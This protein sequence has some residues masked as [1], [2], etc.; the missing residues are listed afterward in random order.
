MWMTIIRASSSSSSSSSSSG[1][2]QSEKEGWE[3][4]PLI[5]VA[6]YSGF[7]LPRGCKF[8]RAHLWMWVQH[9]LDCIIWTQGKLVSTL[10][11]YWSDLWNATVK[12]SRCA[13]RL[14]Y[15]NMEPHCVCV[16]F[17][18]SLSTFL[19]LYPNDK[20]GTDKQQVSLLPP[21][22]PVVRF[23]IWLRKEQEALSK[24]WG[25][26]TTTTKKPQLH[27]RTPQREK[28]LSFKAKT[29]AS[30]FF[31]CCNSTQLKLELYSFFFF[32]SVRNWIEIQKTK[33]AKQKNIQGFLNATLLFLALTIHYA[34][35]VH[36]DR[37]GTIKISCA[38]ICIDTAF[39]VC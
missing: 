16:C 33:K 15:G 28:K 34:V 10:T 2:R 24:A 17:S 6:I 7:V 39:T 29:T 38:W 27:K 19:S 11:V 5:S 12:F 23:Q 26:T 36:S 9:V 8:V 14:M 32:S 37:R 3:R 20:T 13:R 18:I 4:C 35:S 1:I 21:E 22:D 25:T 31:V 30:V